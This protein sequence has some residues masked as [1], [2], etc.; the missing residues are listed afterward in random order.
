MTREQDVENVQRALDQKRKLMESKIAMM[1]AELEAE[2]VEAKQ[3]MAQGDARRAT[4]V[5]D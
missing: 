3:A 5:K 2:E 1:R 4:L